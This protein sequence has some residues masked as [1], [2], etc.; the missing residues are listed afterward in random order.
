MIDNCYWLYW[1]PSIVDKSL[2]LAEFNCWPSPN[3]GHTIVGPL[4]N[5]GCIT[6]KPPMDHA[7]PLATVEKK[8][9][10]Y[11][12]KID[13]N[14]LPTARLPAV[15]TSMIVTESFQKWICL[16]WLQQRSSSGA[17]FWQLFVC[18]SGYSAEC[19]SL[20]LN[21]LFCSIFLSCFTFL[22]PHWLLFNTVNDKVQLLLEFDKRFWKFSNPLIP[23]FL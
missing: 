14:F 1:S 23:Y 10:D 11:I 7:K 2:L 16:P 19:W 17:T 15:A 12:S 5:H 6:D 9:K 13:H 8:S 21:C 18:L 4:P 3:Y 22:I 20:N